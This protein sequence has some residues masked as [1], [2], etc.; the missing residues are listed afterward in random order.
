[1]K[2]MITAVLLIAMLLCGC[3]AN[4][5]EKPKQQPE[6]SA[7]QQESHITDNPLLGTWINTGTYE[8]GG[9]YEEILTVCDDGTV[10]V[11]LNYQGT[12][13]TT[14]TGTYVLA[15]NCFSVTIDSVD[16]PFSTDYHYAVDGRQLTLTDF[17][18]TY[19][20]LRG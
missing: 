17:K 5:A 12:Y 19:T 18:G 7:T 20:Y 11:T 10:I 2:R 4:N 13:Y 1:M 6:E 8:N 15:A 3:T 9:A 14:L 16:E